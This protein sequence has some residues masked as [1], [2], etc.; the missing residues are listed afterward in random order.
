MKLFTTTVLSNL[1]CKSDSLLH[2]YI[3]T[4][5]H[6]EYAYLCLFTRRAAQ[7]YVLIRMHTGLK[8][9]VWRKEVPSKQEFFEIFSF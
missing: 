5:T 3:I 1:F 7:T 2:L 8:Y 9:A 6:D 4:F